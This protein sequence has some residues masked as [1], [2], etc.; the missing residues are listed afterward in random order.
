MA[1]SLEGTF[2][3]NCSCNV[4][5]PCTVSLDSGADNDRCEVVL[6]FNVASGNVDG[7]DVSG[8]TVAVVADTPNVMT[9]GNWRMGLIINDSA[10]D[11]Q[12]EK[13]GAVF[14]GQLGGPMAGL[15]PL[16]GEMLGI[17]R[18]PIEFDENGTHRTKIG[19][20]IEIEVED[21]V[22]FGVETGQPAQ[23][24][25]IFHPA[26][27]T[28]TIGKASKSRVSAFGMEFANEGKHGASAPFSWSG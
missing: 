17:E 1:W 19:D 28:V 22:P 15:A 25:G 24:T 14:G 27:S 4:L 18:A 5:C 21:V 20:G 26:N 23:I 8:S 6:V 13:L 11:E 2:F 7:V 10:S 9:E 16:V 3:E 12:A